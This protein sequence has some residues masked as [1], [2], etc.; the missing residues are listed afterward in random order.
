MTV[1]EILYTID[2]HTYVRVHASDGTEFA[3]TCGKRAT[4]WFV[5]ELAQRS[6]ADRIVLHTY[7]LWHAQE[8]YLDV[9]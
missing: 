3:G 6:M 2:T 9:M 7:P 4:E 8:L 5:N 1:R